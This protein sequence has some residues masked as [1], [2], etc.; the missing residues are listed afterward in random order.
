MEK[1]DRRNA[2]ESPRQDEGR[3]AQALMQTDPATGKGV[4]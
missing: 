1:E 2:S 4:S 3:G